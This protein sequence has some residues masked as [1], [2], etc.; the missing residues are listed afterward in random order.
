LAASYPTA[1]PDAEDRGAGESGAATPE[2]P[3][4]EAVG[5]WKSFGRVEVLLGVNLSVARGEIVALVGD[6]GAG[7]STLLKILSG[8]ESLDAGEIHIDGRTIEMRTAADAQRLGVETVYQDLALAPH[9][10][11]SANLFLGRETLRP[12]V[13]GGLG[14]IDK[15]AMLRAASDD[16]QLLGLRVREDLAS[17]R[18]VDLSGGQ[19]QAVAVARALTW[20][21]RLLI[22]DEPTA[23]LGVRETAYV[24][25]A[26]RKA[27]DERGLSVLLVT[28]D[29][30]SA[31]RIADRVVVLRLGRECASFDARSVSVEQLVGTITGV[32]DGSTKTSAS[33]AS[34]AVL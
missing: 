18:V 30:L 6:N 12:G 16:L 19:Q 28:H 23:A 13:L 11:V 14:F 15:K 33:E 2:S 31:R 10:D 34:E 8:V 24:L 27:R 29:L 17:S 25:D 4:I 3:V 22:L 21:R 20:G 26:V 7:K 5:V 1:S 32:F 9:L